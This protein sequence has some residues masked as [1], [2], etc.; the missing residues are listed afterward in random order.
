MPIDFTLPE[1]GENIASG[2]IVNILVHEGQRIEAN[3]GVVELETEKAIVEIP[4]PHAGTVAKIHVKK[5]DT[6]RV[7]QTLVT[8]EA[9]GAAGEEPGQVPAASAPEARPATAVSQPATAPPG[10]ARPAALAHAPGEVLPAGPAARRL[11]RELGVDLSRVEGTGA[12]GRITPED[13]RSAA[14]PAPVAAVAPV[15][16]A[17]HP[18][19][20]L[21][22]PVVPPGE[23]DRDAWGDIR[24]EKMSQIR[25][26][27]AAQMARSASTV[28]HVTNFDDADITDLEQI[29]KSVPPGFFGPDLKIT[30]MPFLMKAVA[31]SLRRHPLLNASLDESQQQIV[32]KQYVNLG[33]AVDTPRGLVVP[34][35]R[36]ADGMSIGQLAQALASLAE[37]ARAAKFSLEE[38]RGGT[39]TISNMGA[40]GGTYSTP[41]INVPEVAIL[42][43]GRSRW[44]PVVREGRIEPRYLL[45]L[46]L[47][48]DHRLVD[49][50]AAARFLNEVI[51]F[52]QT[53]GKLLLAG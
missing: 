17:V 18:A 16:A 24:R 44:L 40:V 41:I 28:P 27:I 13:V 53:P 6:V 36:H 14:A 20:A 7:G 5:G 34:V 15:P 39:F 8:I 1:L 50:A 46:S 35:V 52:L 45:P 49:G 26:A 37:R 43:V 4:C 9:E 47:S 38:T 10:T 3:Q 30:L 29:R 2:D 42:L 21:F 12:R 22:E 25:R 51:G 23:P 31:L 48:Y 33:I 32:Y 19:P 11:A